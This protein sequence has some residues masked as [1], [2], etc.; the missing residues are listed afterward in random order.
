MFKEY[1]G[2]R[3]EFDHSKVDKII[4]EHIEKGIPGYV[5]S[6]DMTNF[7]LARTS[8]EHLE[9]VNAS[10]VNNCDSSWIPVLVNRLYHTNYTFYRGDDV[11]L[12]FIR[13]CKYRQFFLGSNQRVLDGLKTEMSKID[14]KIQEMHFEELPFRKV[15][16]FDYEGIAKMINDNAPDIIWVSLGCPKQEQFMARLKP[17]LKKGIMFGYGA[18]FNFYSGLDDVEQAAPKWV[19]NNRLQFIYRL[20]QDP[21]KQWPRVKRIL[22][23]V[24]SSIKEEKRKI[25]Q[26]KR[27]TKN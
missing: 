2:I 9:L 5:V 21:K 1:F 18:I 7:S 17:Y 12:G 27:F 20:F 25:A 14:P 10:I 16:E 24:P 23:C 6:L 8:K 11:F 3:W 15:E 22:Q 13:K 4:E 26:E 19:V